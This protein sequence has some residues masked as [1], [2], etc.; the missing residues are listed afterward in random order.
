MQV[1]VALRLEVDALGLLLGRR[2]PQA[3]V[4]PLGDAVGGQVLPPAKLVFQHR[5]LQGGIRVR[6]EVVVARRAIGR[7]RSARVRIAAEV[8]PVRGW[9][10]A[11]AEHRP[12]S[13]AATDHR[14]SRRQ[15]AGTGQRVIGRP[16]IGRTE[17]PP[18]IRPARPIVDGRG[19]I[20]AMVRPPLSESRPIAA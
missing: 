9:Q 6:I 15:E 8:G 3:D 18:I 11:V 12:V 17:I 7:V 16:V 19:T 20:P 5:F 13:I 2:R 10:I 14:R 4:H 1:D